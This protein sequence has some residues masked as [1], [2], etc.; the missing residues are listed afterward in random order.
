MSEA[1]TM[2]KAGVPAVAGRQQ[3]N[4]P[5]TAVAK[6]PIPG[7]ELSR[8]NAA[9]HLTSIQ[10]AAVVLA[11]IGP[12]LSNACLNGLS[13]Q[14]ISRL[15]H[16]LGALGRVSQEVLDGVIIEFLEVLMEGAELSGGE[17]VTRELLTGLIPDDEINRILGQVT[18][19][20]G[21]G[22]WGRLNAAPAKALAN[23]LAAEHPQTVAVIVTELRADVAANVLAELDRDFAQSIVLRLAR[24][25][26]MDESVEMAMQAAI[27]RDFLSVLQSSLSKRRPAELIAGLMNNISSEVRDAFLGHLESKNAPL[28]LEVQRTMFT[29]D[30]I[31]TRL[32]P[33]DVPG[34][35]REVEE[36]ALL[37]ALKRGQATESPSVAFILAN[38]PRRLSERYATDLE[39]MEAVTPKDGEAAQIELAKMILQMSQSNAI[40]LL[41]VE[42][43]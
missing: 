6:F 22:L 5:G 41:E 36:E 10:K 42:P 2:D 27:E 28:A 20:P 37:K 29:F 30:D 18:A 3:Q 34:V 40:Q 14:H 33:R 13:E 25:P 38:L 4:G 32:S 12:E 11:A 43:A 35:M 23:F 7:V 16:T 17:R 24:I 39:E 9:D 31:A 21:R 26:T 1:A 19:G 15:A 8:R